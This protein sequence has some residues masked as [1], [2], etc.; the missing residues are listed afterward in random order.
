MTLMSR[1]MQTLTR[2]RSEEAEDVI[3]QLEGA[4]IRQTQAAALP[5]WLPPA[6]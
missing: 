3:L 6:G 5:A 4:L 2:L 1:S